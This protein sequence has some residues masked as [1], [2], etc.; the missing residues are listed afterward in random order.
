MIKPYSLD[1]RERAVALA[2]E[3]ASRLRFWG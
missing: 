1:L 3:G 2:D